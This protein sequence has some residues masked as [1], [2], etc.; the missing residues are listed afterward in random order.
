MSNN[1]LFVF[2]KISP[3]AEFFDD[4]KNAILNIVLQTREESG[5]IQFEVH[6]NEEKDELYLYEEWKSAKDL[7]SH[8]EKSY[9]LDIF[10]SYENWLAR[11]VVITKM[12]E[13]EKS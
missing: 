3:K 8:H 6:E 11:P 4:A 12:I 1:S 10:K 9:T 7:Q 13:C 5:C 2:A